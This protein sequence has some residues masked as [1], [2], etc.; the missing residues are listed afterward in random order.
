MGMMD[1]KVV[2]VTGAGRGVGRGVALLMAAEGARVVVNDIG[3]ALDGSGS[4]E[5]PAQEVVGEI[6]AAGGEAGPARHADR[7]VRVGAREA[8]A[9]GREAIQIGCL[10]DR[11]AGVPGHLRVVLVGQD[12]DQVRRLHVQ[13]L[14]GTTRVA[15]HLNAAGILAGSRACRTGATYWNRAIVAALAMPE[16]RSRLAAE[17]GEPVGMTPAQA[18]AFHLEVVTRWGERMQKSGIRPE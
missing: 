17:A 1:G 4:A 13:L 5:T 12:D 14:R 2:V 11:V 10:H 18:G 7:A 3:A 16:V 8:R 9:A 15:A 6:V